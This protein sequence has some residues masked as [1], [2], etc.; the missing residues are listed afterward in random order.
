MSVEESWGG[1]QG[2]HWFLS[3]VH[4][5]GRDWKR[6]SELEKPSLNKNYMPLNSLW[7]GSSSH[8][9]DEEMDSQRVKGP[10]AG[11]RASYGL[12]RLSR[13]SPVGCS[14]L[15]GNTPMRQELIM[16]SPAWGSQGSEEGGGDE[17]LFWTESWSCGPQLGQRGSKS[18]D[19]Y[20]GCSNGQH[21]VRG[22]LSCLRGWRILR[23]QTVIPGFRNGWK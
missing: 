20:H 22:E 23:D 16:F 11:H 12:V 4:K 6:E 17:S 19:H 3:E 9:T 1:S 8:F 10:V 13:C 5:Q 2:H 14:R 15:S 18:A 7:G 21:P